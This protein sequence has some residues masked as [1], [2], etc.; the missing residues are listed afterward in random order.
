MEGSTLVHLAFAA[1]LSLG[2]VF[3][4]SALSKLR[5]PAA[6]ARSVVEYQILPGEVAYLFGLI[7]IPSEAFLAIAL[8]TGFAPNVTLLLTIGMLVVFLVAVGINLRRGRQ[9]SCGCF[10]NATEKI[11]PRTLARLLLLL[12]VTLLLL[13][14]Q[15][16][17]N[18][19]SLTLTS[20]TA[21]SSALV[22][23]LYTT[24]LALFLLL[25]GAWV[26]SLPEVAALIRHKR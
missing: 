20:L 9:V 22:Y 18:A 7:L 24:F 8:L 13:A 12:C 2:I 5:Q 6:F 23:L 4:L 11:S 1:Q 26:L 16:M 19:P 21:D 15:N 10:G 25:M 3:F 14:Y 17:G